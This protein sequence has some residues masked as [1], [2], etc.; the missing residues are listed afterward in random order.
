MM[1]VHVATQ[2]TICRLYLSQQDCLLTSYLC[3]FMLGPPLLQDNAILKVE[4]NSGRIPV[5][6]SE[7][8]VVFPEPVF[9]WTKDGQPLNGSALTYKSIIFDNVRREDAGNYTVLATNFVINSTT[10]KQVGNDTGSFYLDVL[11]KL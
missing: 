10:L 9:R 4:E 8:L 3:T 5:N 6:L 1:H 11:C 7:G 2:C